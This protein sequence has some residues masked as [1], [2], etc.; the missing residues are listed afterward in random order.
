MIE[1]HEFMLHAGAAAVTLGT[2]LWRGKGL[3]EKVVAGGEPWL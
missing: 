3:L 2:V 1:G